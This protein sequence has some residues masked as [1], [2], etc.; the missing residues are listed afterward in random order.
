MRLSRISESASRVAAL[1]RQEPAAKR[2]L[3][4]PP[5]W[6]NGGGDAY[7]RA[8]L[9]RP[10]DKAPDRRLSPVPTTA[11]DRLLERYQRAAGCRS[12]AAP[13]RVRVMLPQPSPP[14]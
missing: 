8:G 3:P 11:F 14:P 13:L 7:A 5:L 2:G 10:D 4:S 1:H 12:I 9:S 6:F